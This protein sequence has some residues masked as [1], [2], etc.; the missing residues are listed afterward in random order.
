MLEARIASH[1]PVAVNHFAE[2]MDEAMRGATKKLIHAL[3]HKLGKLDRHEHRSR[4]TIRKD[5]DVV[6]EPLS[7]L[8]DGDIR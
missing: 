7:S 1:P 5:P 8:G 6:A 4:E 2:N 3:E